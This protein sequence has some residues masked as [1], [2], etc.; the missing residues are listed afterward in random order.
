V[1]SSTTKAIRITGD[2]VNICARICSAAL[3]GE[4]LL[5]EDATA[6]LKLSTTDHEEH[7]VVAMG[8]QHTINVY[9]FV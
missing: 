5:S 9:G 2:P 4:L 8:K 1:G 7:Q 3:P 6:V